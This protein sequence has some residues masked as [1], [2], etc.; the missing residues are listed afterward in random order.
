MALPS[1]SNPCMVQNVSFRVTLGWFLAGRDRTCVVAGLSEAGR[2]RYAGVTDP[3]YNCRYYLALNHV[4][5]RDAR[6]RT[7]RKIGHGTRARWFLFLPNELQSTAHLFR[8]SAIFPA[9]PF[10]LDVFLVDDGKSRFVHVL[11]LLRIEV[12]ATDELE[13]D[14]VLG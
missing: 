2:C 14:L 8:G 10:H 9:G 6:R 3:G 12:A 7:A 11:V 5:I 4:R 1:R 13:D